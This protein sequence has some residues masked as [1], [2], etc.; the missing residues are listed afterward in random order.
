MSQRRWGTILAAAVVSLV[1]ASPAYAAVGQPRTGSPKYDRNPSVVR[2]GGTTYLF[3]ARSQQD[4]NRLTTP[5]PLLCPD[6]L[7]YDLY[8]KTSADGGLDHLG[9]AA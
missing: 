4:C 1:L 5:M 6:N 7:D 3:F 9:P 2:N 8:Y